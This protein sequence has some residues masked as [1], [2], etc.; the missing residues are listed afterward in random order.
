MP[1]NEYV[2]TH[3]NELIRI[4]GEIY[5]GRIME[6][7]INPDIDMDEFEK[8]CCKDAVIIHKY[9]KG[10]VDFPVTAYIDPKNSVKMSSN[11][12]DDEISLDLYTI[13]LCEQA[14]KDGSLEKK[15]NRYTQKGLMKNPKKY[16]DYLITD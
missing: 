9:N 11:Q 3:K 14:V 1:S 12:Q 6:T 4:F 15:G 10:V 7:Y 2:S 13:I 16:G 8:S 5:T